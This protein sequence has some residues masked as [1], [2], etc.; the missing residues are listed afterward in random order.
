MVTILFGGPAVPGGPVA[1]RLRIAP[2]LLLSEEYQNN[3][4]F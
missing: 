1:L 2:D 3:F 4:K